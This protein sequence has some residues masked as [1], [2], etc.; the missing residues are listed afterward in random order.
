MKTLLLIAVLLWGCANGRACSP[1]ELRQCQEKCGQLADACVS[2]G[3]SHVECMD[4]YSRCA[5]ACDG[6]QPAPSTQRSGSE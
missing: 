2:E 1:A 6:V 3:I 5:A 4:A